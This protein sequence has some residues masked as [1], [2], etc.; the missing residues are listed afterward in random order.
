MK[1][2]DLINILS[3]EYNPNA[4]VIGVEWATGRT[5]KVCIGGDDEEEGEKICS[6]SFA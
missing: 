5:F 3:K 2:K 1:V 6:V 4:E